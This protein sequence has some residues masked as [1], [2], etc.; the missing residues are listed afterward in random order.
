MPEEYSLLVKPKKLGEK[1]TYNNY[2]YKSRKLSFL[3]K[4]SLFI[5]QK[6]AVALNDILINDSRVGKSQ[7]I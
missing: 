7:F 3:F 4:E 5:N 2:T 1:N 6:Y